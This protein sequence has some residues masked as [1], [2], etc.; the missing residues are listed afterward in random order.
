[1]DTCQGSR[2]PWRPEPGTAYSL[3]GLGFLHASEASQETGETAKRPRT[4]Q[5]VSLIEKGFLTVIIS[6]V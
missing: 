2:G 3:S 4:E 1:M 6:F 5:I